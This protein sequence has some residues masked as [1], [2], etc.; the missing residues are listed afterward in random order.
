[1]TELR[2]DLPVEK[3]S[4]AIFI[5]VD[6]GDTI[7]IM[8]NTC[9]YEGHIFY[10]GVDTDQPETD[11]LGNAIRHFIDIHPELLERS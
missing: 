7:T 6:G 11:W 10:S 5:S 3:L 1:M 2:V 4:G 9:T 8:C